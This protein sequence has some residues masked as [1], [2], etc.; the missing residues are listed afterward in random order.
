[1][2]HLL[3]ADDHAIVRQG[4]LMLLEQI[5]EIKVTKEAS[6]GAETLQAIQSNNFDLVLLDIALPDINGL[7][8]LK[9]IKKSHPNLPVLILSMHPEKQYALRALRAGASGYL[10]KES[11]PHELVN[12]LKKVSSGGRY[13]TLSLVEQLMNEL[14][15]NFLD[16]K[17]QL[18]SDREY[19]V[20]CLISEGKSPKDIAHSL[21]ISTK[22]V[23][24]Y[25]KRILEKLQLSTTSELI[26][27]A[28][29]H[30]LVD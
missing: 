28:V 16:E 27:Y 25:R 29:D 13:V 23:S 9:Q 20:L 8:V 1:M 30:H 3:V 11:A 2:K 15:T 18:L 14:D 6:N 26:R 24:T 7:E 22:T 19:Q 12:A 21:S 17:H 10:T 4:V 5:P